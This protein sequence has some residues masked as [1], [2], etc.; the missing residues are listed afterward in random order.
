LF[1]L[2]WLRKEVTYEKTTI[3]GLYI[4]VQ[5]LQIAA[6]GIQ[7]AQAIPSSGHISVTYRHQETD[8]YCGPAVVQ[9]A[10]DYL[11]TA[12]PSQDQLAAE[13]Q[14]NIVEGV[15][16][17]DMMSIPFTN[18]NFSEVYADTLSF[19]EL[20]ENNANGYLTII[21]IYFDTTHEHQH[22][23]LVVGYNASGAFVHDPW[24]VAWGSP[25]GRTG[26]ENAYIS[27]ELLTELWACYPSHWGLVIPHAEASGLSQSPWQRYWPILLVIPVALAGV[28]VAIYTRRRKHTVKDL[29]STDFLR[30]FSVHVCTL[31]VVEGFK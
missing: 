24:P 16:Y 27:N 17:I 1:I 4:L 5:V 20:K 10:L 2:F 6:I 30:N 12:L 3:H 26:G 13:M 29:S 21:L 31:D 23:V 22:Y 11:D 8:C 25:E 28:I 18:R 19:D 15:T 9:M 7:N 14:T